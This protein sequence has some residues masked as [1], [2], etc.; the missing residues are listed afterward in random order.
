[1]VAQGRTCSRDLSMDTPTAMHF[2]HV[3]GRFTY[4]Q[5]DLGWDA[6]AMAWIGPAP[7]LGPNARLCLQASHGDHPPSILVCEVALATLVLIERMDQDARRYLAIEAEGYIR[8]TYHR[9]AG[10]EDFSVLTLEMN[11]ESCSDRFALTYRAGFDAGAVW[12]VRFKGL[13]PLHWRVEHEASTMPVADGSGRSDPSASHDDSEAPLPLA[14]LGR[15]WLGPFAW[16]A[17]P[18]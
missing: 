5:L 10:P 17:R 4:R 14:R 8:N 7:Q 6:E 1:M 12:K 9:L 3:N 13:V 16:I 11:G 2:D 18:A 15:R